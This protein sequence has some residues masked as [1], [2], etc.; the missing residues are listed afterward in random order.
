[1]KALLVA[2]IAVFQ[3]FNS[4]PSV[5]SKIGALLGWGGLF[6]AC[7]G[8]GCSHFLKGNTIQ[9]VSWG[10]FACIVGVYVTL[11]WAKLWERKWLR[12]NPVP[13]VET[14]VGTLQL[15]TSPNSVCHEFLVVE[16]W[17]RVIEELKQDSYELVESDSAEQRIDSSVHKANKEERNCICSRHNGVLL[18]PEPFAEASLDRTLID[19]RRR[20]RSLSRTATS[21]R[22]RFC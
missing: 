2:G 12:A 8:V 16:H 11:T 22:V 9:I 20:C 19:T 10:G 17:L 14:T 6:T 1:M 5:L 13:S 15:N 4:L 3:A 18:T 21:A 7:L